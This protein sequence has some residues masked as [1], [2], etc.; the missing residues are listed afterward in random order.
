MSRNFTI[1]LNT[2]ISLH[3]NCNIL[4]N[5]GIISATSIFF[6]FLIFYLYQLFEG[7]YIL[8]NNTEPL[9]ISLILLAKI[10]LECNSK[11]LSS[12]SL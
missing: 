5:T 10:F 3:S 12:N 11:N 1:S 6:F 7:R 9:L 8:L 2:C 4:N